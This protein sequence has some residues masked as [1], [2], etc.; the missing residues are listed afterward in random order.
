[1]KNKGSEVEAN[2]VITSKRR[3]QKGSTSGNKFVLKNKG[4]Q[5]K[6]EKGKGTTPPTTTAK[7]KKSVVEKGKCF[8]CSGDGHWKRNCPKYLADKKAGKENQGKYDLM[9]LE[10]FIVENNDSTWILDSRATDHVRS[11]F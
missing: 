4:I 7:G 6:K 9:V 3:F 5:K 10:T 11:Y 8:Y 2:V 1:M